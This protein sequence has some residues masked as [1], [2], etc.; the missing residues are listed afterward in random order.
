VPIE[1][2]VG[3]LPRLTYQIYFDTKLDAA[4]AEL[5][6]DVRRTI[7]ATLRT[8]DSPPPAEYLKSSNSF[9][10]AWSHVKEVCLMLHSFTISN[11]SQIPP[12]PFLTSEEED[13]LVKQY[14]I[15]G[16]RNCKSS[17]YHDTKY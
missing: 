8:V 2:L 3:A 5:D 1:A 13:Y 14:S 12:V 6:K 16:F 17:L 11:A 7:R 9:L 15:Q 10:G 4:V